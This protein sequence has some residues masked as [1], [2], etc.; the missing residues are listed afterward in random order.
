MYV[1]LPCLNKYV[2][3]VYRGGLFTAHKLLVLR[4]TGVSKTNMI[5]SSEHTLVNALKNIINSC[6]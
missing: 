2:I 6:A 1:K 3:A 4:A 5:L